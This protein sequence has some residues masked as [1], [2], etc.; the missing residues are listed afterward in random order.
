MKITQGNFT[1]DLIQPQRLI[2]SL[3]S[4][5]FFSNEIC[6]VSTILCLLFGS[7]RRSAT[8]PNPCRHPHVKQGAQTGPFF[9]H[10]V[11]QASVTGVLTQLRQWKIRLH[12]SM[13]IA[14]S[15]KQCNQGLMCTYNFILDISL[16]AIYC[17]KG[18]GE[19]KRGG[20]V[21]RPPSP[22][23]N[24]AALCLKAESLQSP[25]KWQ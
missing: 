10:T 3:M 25:N 17:L 13:L 21:S 22:K 11:C 16:T 19:G 9:P 7:I 2:S 12:F 4:Q 5:P 6:F 24:P 18:R 8:P 14:M 20:E 1:E 23:T 15:P